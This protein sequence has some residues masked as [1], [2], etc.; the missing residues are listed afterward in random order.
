LYSSSFFGCR[1][2]YDRGDYAVPATLADYMNTAYMEAYH[3]Y[4]KACEKYWQ[5][6]KKPFIGTL[7]KNNH[8]FPSEPDKKMYPLPSYYPTSLLLKSEGKIWRDVL[9]GYTI[10]SPYD[11]I[12]TDFWGT[13]YS[14]RVT[15]DDIKKT[16]SMCDFYKT[17]ECLKSYLVY[18][19]NEIQRVR[20][21][22]QSDKA[23]L[24]QEIEALKNEVR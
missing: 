13:P 14:S 9:W 23:K 4:Q 7:Y 12:K 17:S 16:F 20:F 18:C 22:R 19:D 11:K 1:W 21:Q 6:C 5:K 24:E 15:A 8:S 2:D 10:S 3:E